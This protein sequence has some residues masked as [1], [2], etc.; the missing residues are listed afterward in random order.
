MLTPAIRAIYI[1]PFYYEFNYL[2]LSLNNPASL[3]NG[4]ARIPIDISKINQIISGT[5]YDIA[6]N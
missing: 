4:R 5:I 6:Q 2:K 3:L 1:T